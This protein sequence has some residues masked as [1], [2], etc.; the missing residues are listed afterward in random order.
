MPTISARPTARSRWWCWIP[1]V[2]AETEPYAVARLPPETCS[3]DDAL[4]AV[5]PADEA[6]PVA[7]LSSRPRVEPKA[8][9]EG[10]GLEGPSGAEEG[11]IVETP[12]AAPTA[13]HE[14][15]PE[16]ERLGCGILGRSMK[17]LFEGAHERVRVGPQEG[18]VHGRRLPLARSDDALGDGAQLVA[19]RGEAGGDEREHGPLG[20]AGP[21]TRDGEVVLER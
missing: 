1:P 8:A 6:D 17:D 10:R 20:K 12:A 15:Q 2:R 13:L 9:V 3:V 5:L 14:N 18:G 21:L 19:E 11:G 4:P 7:H 16:G